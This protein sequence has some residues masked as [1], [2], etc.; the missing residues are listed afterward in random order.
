MGVP[1]AEAIGD[2][3]AHSKSPL[4]HKF[5]LR[6]LG[7]EGDYWA[8]RV[9][10]DELPAYLEARRADP[11]WRGC[12][13]TMPLKEAAY[14]L[15]DVDPS[16]RRIGALNT[17]VRYEDMLIG[18]NTDWQALNLALDTYRLN[19]RRAVII[20]TGGAACAAL[21]EMRVNRVPQVDIVSR[22]PDKAEA[23][24]QRFGLSG[25]ALRHEASPK[26]DLL[27]N[28]S[29]LGM[30]GFPPL[31]I[32]LSNLVAGATV[33]E[34]VYRPLE[35]PLLRAARAAGFR[36]I[37]GLRMLMEQAAMAFTFFFKDSP[38]PIDDDRLRELLTR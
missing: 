28:A 25:D 24:L 4:I 30:E 3:I 12:N 18:H 17:V 9:T 21:E 11:D 35:T 8:T 23:L 10:A 27:V 33:V 38:H 29:P 31:D 6:K 22:H 26:A 16:T 19:P 5:W 14:E 32:D 13:V 15:L 36:T 7:I 34:M 20:G 37:D 2:P 1:Y